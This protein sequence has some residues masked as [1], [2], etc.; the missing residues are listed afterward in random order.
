MFWSS[1][2]L[3][4]KSIFLWLWP[5]QPRTGVLT[6]AAPPLN[7]S[8]Q[9]SHYPPASS[10]LPASASYLST[11][12]HAFSHTLRLSPSN[13]QGRRDG[14]SIDWAALVSAPSESTGYTCLSEHKLSATSEPPFPSSASQGSHYFTIMQLERSLKFSPLFAASQS[15]AGPL[16]V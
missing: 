5:T 4:F 14:G 1:L 8:N 3:F 13:D 11:G 12:L 16:K 15:C 9:P 2:F 7:D 6:P 10:A